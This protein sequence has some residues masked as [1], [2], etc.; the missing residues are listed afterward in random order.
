MDDSVFIVQS[1]QLIVQINNADGS[2]LSLKH[3][4]Q[5]ESV[6]SLL[7]FV[8]ILVVSILHINQQY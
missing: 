8:D 5:G 7:S 1:G 2:T 4:K 3:V 6:T